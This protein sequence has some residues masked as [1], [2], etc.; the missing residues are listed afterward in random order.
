MI[1]DSLLCLSSLLISVF[2]INPAPTKINMP[3]TTAI[4]VIEI[5]GAANKTNAINVITE[6]IADSGVRA[7]V[8]MFD[9][10]RLKELQLGKQDRKLPA[11]FAIP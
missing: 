9:A 6:T 11:I 4:G 10:L 2:L 8:S 1:R 5:I 3:A 7:P